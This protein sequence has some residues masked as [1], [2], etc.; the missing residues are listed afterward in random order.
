MV[1]L[2][3]SDIFKTWCTQVLPNASVL[4]RLALFAGVGTG[5]FLVN[6]VFSCR[7]VRA[8]ILVGVSVE[9]TRN[10]LQAGGGRVVIEATNAVA[11]LNAGGAWSA[12]GV[13]HA[14]LTNSTT[15]GRVLLAI[16]VAGAQC[17]R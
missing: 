13:V 4:A 17:A 11:V 9:F 3:Q 2:G 6:G 7:T 15:H 10:T 1:C 5:S 14:S 16:C 8:L 12:G